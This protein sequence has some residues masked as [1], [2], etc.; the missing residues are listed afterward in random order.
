MITPS[1][2]L[3]T[4]AYWSENVILLTQNDI[5]ITQLILLEYNCSVFLAQT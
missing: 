5:T 3:I 1:L 2:F 4:T